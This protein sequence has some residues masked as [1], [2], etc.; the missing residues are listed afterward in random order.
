[1]SSLGALAP[2]LRVWSV[3]GHRLHSPHFAPSHGQR[4]PLEEMAGLREEE[5]VAACKDLA[6]SFSRL[7]A[8]EHH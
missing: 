8:G 7:P 2:S 4:C 5:A 6:G 1:M 3:S